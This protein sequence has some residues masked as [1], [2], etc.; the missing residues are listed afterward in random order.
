M[1]MVKEWK[2]MPQDVVCYKAASKT[3]GDWNWKGGGRL[4]IVY[5]IV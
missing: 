3:G 2:K 1:G 5:F 4:K